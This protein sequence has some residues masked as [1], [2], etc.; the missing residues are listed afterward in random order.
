MAQTS[1]PFGDIVYVQ[2]PNIDRAV[3]QIQAQHVAQQ[4]YQQHSNL[5]MDQMVNKEFAKARSADI[6]NIVNSYQQ[7]K[8][9]QQKLLFDP[10]TKNDPQA[11][12]AARQQANAALADTYTQINRSSELNNLGKELIAERKVKAPL[13]ADDFGNKISAFMSTPMDKL[14]DHP[15][16]DLTNPDTYRYKGGQTDFAKKEKDAAGTVRA[17]VFNKE[18]KVSDFQS[19][20]TPYSFGNSPAQ[21]FETYKGSLGDHQSFRD[22]SAAWE[23]IPQTQKDEVDRQ[24]SQIP[25]EKWQQMTGKPAPQNIAPADPT[26]PA[27][28]YAAYRAKVYAI[29]AT[30][31]EG[32]P[33]PQ[34]N[35]AMKMQAQ[36]TDWYKKEAQRHVD[37]T[38]EI[39]SRFNNSK[40]L[41]YYKNTLTN[42]EAN[43]PSVDQIETALQNPAQ[44][45]GG[46]LMVQQAQ[47]V[48]ST[49]NSQGNTAN[50]QTKLT[51]IPS[52]TTPELNQQKGFTSFLNSASKSIQGAYESLPDKAGKWSQVKG[53]L[54]NPQV[55][56]E[57]KKKALADAYNEINA[58][59]GSPVRFTPDDLTNAVPALYERNDVFSTGNK[60]T[61]QLVKVGTP[62]FGNVINEKRNAFLSSKKPVLKSQEEQPSMPAPPTPGKTST[63]TKIK[64]TE[65]SLN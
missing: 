63:T 47:D 56:V 48:L 51:L 33:Y 27:E 2:T 9:L 52:F 44:K 37:R 20:V 62:E 28:N 50:T 57:D 8:T 11:Y 31:L 24:Y 6:P 1:A 34:V 23:T 12:N 65:G 39:M 43:T 53:V 14:Q 61:Y 30:P 59:N 15:L 16:G 29:N 35:Q 41:A 4:Q 5:L 22:A 40:S 60:K 25:A 26:N 17:G 45:A 21:F 10:K 49:W 18:D 13:Y 55:P 36:Q 19:N 64:L 3:Q 32:K 38:A 46:K 42:P 54:D 58:A 7:W